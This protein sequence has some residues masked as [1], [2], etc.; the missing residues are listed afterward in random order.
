M[1][2]LIFGNGWLGNRCADTWKKENTH[3]VV[4]S[5][6]FIQTGDDVISEIKK[7]NPNVVLNA[8][9]VVGKP[10]VDWCETNQWQTILSNTTLPLLIARVCAQERKYFLHIGTGC[11]YYGY[12]K[13]GWLP[14][15]VAN[16][17][18]V[19]TKTKYAADLALS[20]IPNVGIARIRMPIDTIPNP[21]NLLD[22][23]TRYNKIINMVNSVTVVPDMIDALRVMLEKRSGGI[24]HIVNHGGIKT[25]EIIDMYK[26]FVDNKFKNEWIKEEDLLGKNLVK[27]KRSNNVLNTDKLKEEG[28]P[29]REALDAVEDTI[30]KYG[31]LKKY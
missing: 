9:G 29:M 11:I 4:L 3:E 14:E 31:V 15:D 20:T 25:K 12:K 1:K 26:M 7:H 5:N 8:A 18:A 23:L 28:I 16:P 6:V 2:I 17:Q 10:N 27:C 13:G 19:Y 24:Y 21:A 22:K 30:I